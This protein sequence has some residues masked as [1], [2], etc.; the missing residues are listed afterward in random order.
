MR[1]K[2]AK[3]IRRMVY[4]DSASNVAGR[5]YR[6]DPSRR[7]ILADRK[8]REF[9][10]RKRL[11]RMVRI[12]AERKTTGPSRSEIFRRLVL[13]ENTRATVARLKKAKQAKKERGRR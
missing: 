7:W 13:R 5:G 4:E 6:V 1:G 8:R 3:T 10:I 9:Q 2:V 11:Y 12:F